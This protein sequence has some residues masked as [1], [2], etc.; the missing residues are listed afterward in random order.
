MKTWDK[1]LKDVLPWTPGCPEPIAEHAVLR[2]AQEYLEGTRIWKL[3]LPDITTEAERTEY[4]LDLEPAS[5]LVRLERATLNGRPI[6]VRSVDELPEDW[7]T[8]TSGIEDGV[9]TLDGRTMVLLPAQAADMVVK[10]EASM[11]PSDSAT[12]VEDFIFNRYCAQIATGAVAALKGHTDKSY[13]DLAGAGLWRERFEGHMGISD[14]QR[15]RGFSS[16]RPRRPV[17]TF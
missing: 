11:R 3:W 17:R 12:G 2:A 5:E 15:F 9:H 14:F 4:D 8:Y 7:R 1:F 13:S 16:A 6:R 10:V